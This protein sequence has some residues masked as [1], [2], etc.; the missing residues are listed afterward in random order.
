MSD[1]PLT[2]VA[3]STRRTDSWRAQHDA[4]S[5]KLGITEDVLSW[6]EQR[7]FVHGA[8]CRTSALRH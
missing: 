5:R 2:H 3:P 7:Q 4:I 6:T 1:P 8:A